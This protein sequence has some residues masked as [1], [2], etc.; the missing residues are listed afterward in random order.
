VDRPARSRTPPSAYLSIALSL[1]GYAFA[2]WLGTFVLAMGTPGFDLRTFFLPAGDAVRAGTDP[3]APRLLPGLGP[4]DGFF[5][6]PPWAVFFGAVSWLPW[7]VVYLAIFAGEVAALRIMFGSWRRVGYVLWVP[8]M[9]FELASGNINLIIAATIVVAQRGRT[10]PLA[11]S[12]LAK[13]SPAFAL[14][15]RDGRA[16]AIVFAAACAITLPWLYLWPE[17]IA[18][19]DRA[20]SHGGVGPQI[21]IPFAVRLVA[22]IP[23][24]ALQRPWSRALGAVIAIPGFYY[25]SL[26]LLTAPLAVALASRRPP[27]GSPDHGPDPR[28]GGTD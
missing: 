24:I 8:L 10:G 9:P 4:V 2:I 3:Y 20:L 27:G 22:A 7:Q 23:L 26:V 18:A 19:L 11:L 5:W 28:P 17:W 1:G 14:P 25:V 21:G 12:A 6:A 15:P 13:I 16:F